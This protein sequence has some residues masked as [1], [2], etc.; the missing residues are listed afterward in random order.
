MIEFPLAELP[1]GLALHNIPPPHNLLSTSSPSR[2]PTQHP[3]PDNNQAL[4]NHIDMLPP[5]TRYFL[6][7]LC[8]SLCCSSYH[9]MLVIS[10]HS[11]A[12][13]PVLLFECI[14][15]SRSCLWM[16][17]SRTDLSLACTYI[18]LHDTYPAQTPYSV[19]GNI[20]C[21]FISWIID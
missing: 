11:K 17:L 16:S 6:G 7:L 18:V 21:S 5:P 9:Q 3:L 10:R 1:T 20:R 8:N 12:V 15:D 13:A 2:A 14:A 4:I 19:G